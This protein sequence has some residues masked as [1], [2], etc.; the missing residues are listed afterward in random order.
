MAT[1]IAIEGPAGSGKT[2]LQAELHERGH[3]EPAPRMPMGRDLGPGDGALLSSISDFAAAAQ[4]MAGVTTIADRFIL[5]R[6]VYSR[7]EDGPTV[8]LD[9]GWDSLRTMWAHLREDRMFR[10]GTDSHDSTLRVLFLCL[11]PSINRLRAQR[12]L[13]AAKSYPF[14]G[15]KELEHYRDL[16]DRPWPLIVRNVTVERVVLDVNSGALSIADRAVAAIKEWQ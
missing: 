5:S 6:V 10:S 14:D 11:N 3:G 7:F 16:W 9:R 13:F 8:L 4:A 15:L 1:L 2:T 12:A